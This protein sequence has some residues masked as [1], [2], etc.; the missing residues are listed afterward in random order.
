[1]VSRESSVDNVSIVE[2]SDDDGYYPKQPKSPPKEYKPFLTSF[3]LFPLLPVEIRDIIWRL[4]LPPRTIEVEY[5]AD[6]G[7]YTRVT[8][9]TALKVCSSSRKA[10]IDSYT[11]CFGNILHRPSILFNFSLDTLYFEC[12]LQNRVCQFLVSMSGK[13]FRPVRCGSSIT[14]RDKMSPS[15]IGS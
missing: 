4:T 8:T 12:S 13:L 1:M 5:R 6:R 14:S 2:L 11:L 15:S 3:T 7:F 9:P 10:V